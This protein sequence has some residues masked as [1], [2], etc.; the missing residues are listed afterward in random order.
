[1]KANHLRCLRVPLL[2]LVAL[3]LCLATRAGGQT[4]DQDSQDYYAK[5]QERAGKGNSTDQ[6]NLGVRYFKGEGV[7]R[8]QGRAL[9]WVRA[10]ATNRNK[11]FRLSP[12]LQKEVDEMLSRLEGLATP[13][14]RPQ[15]RAVCSRRCGDW[16]KFCQNL[17]D[18]H[19]HCG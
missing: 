1:M 19:P 5:Q 12:T 17:V 8:D 6:Y 3:P 10:A 11:E 2:L 14:E 18:Y 4:S 15:A 13:S 9:K 7:K 16:P